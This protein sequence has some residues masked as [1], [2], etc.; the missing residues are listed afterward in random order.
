MSSQ[1]QALQTPLPIATSVPAG[2]LRSEMES[3]RAAGERFTVKEAIGIVVP[4]CTQ[5][6]KLHG[7][8]KKLFVHPSD[9]AY[10][11]EGGAQI[12]EDK[13]HTPPTQLATTQSLV[14][15]HAD[16]SAHGEQ[17]A[18]PQSMSVSS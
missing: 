15:K 2:S 17:V 18:P 11:R 14:C 12:L 4:L 13:A 8:G 7:E 1:A 9:L 16:P 3:R 6:A 5:L 10:S